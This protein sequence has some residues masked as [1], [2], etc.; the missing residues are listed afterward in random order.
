MSCHHSYKNYR[1][2]QF[3][4]LHPVH[5][6]VPLPVIS[7]VLIVSIQGYEL[8]VSAI[9]VIEN[10]RSREALV[11]LSAGFKGGSLLYTQKI[12][13]TSLFC[14]VKPTQSLSVCNSRR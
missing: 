8:V 6:P 1:T 14:K 3:S 5:V 11:S 9:V 7:R 10:L 13:E 4:V 12:A 2:A